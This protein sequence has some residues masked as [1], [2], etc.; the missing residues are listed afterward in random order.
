MSILINSSTIT[1]AALVMLENNLVAGN[2]I[3][4]S[5]SDKF[6]VQDNKIGASLSIRRP[7]FG[8]IQT[9]NMAWTSATAQVTETRVNLAINS[10]YTVALQFTDAD[11]ALR[12]ERFIDRY[13][14]PILS[15]VAAKFDLA[16][17]D[18]ISNCGAAGTS[19]FTGQASDIQKQVGGMWVAGSFSTALSADT[20]VYAKQLLLDA[21]CPDDGDIYGVLTTKGNRQLVTT[22]QNLFNPSEEIAK[23][24]KKGYI[25][26][27]NG[28]EFATS[29]STAAHTN[30]GQATLAIGA[31]SAVLTAGWAETGT[32]TVTSTTSAINAGDVFTVAGV[33]AVN[34][35]TKVQT[36]NLQQFTVVNSYTAGT[37]ALE[38]SPAPITG[39][40]Y[41]NIS[42]TVASKTATLVDA[43]GAT[44]QEGY[45][46]HKSAIVAASPEL[47]LPKSSSF[48]MAEYERSEI[49]E[50][51]VR[52]LQGF[53]MYG[54]GGAVGMNTRIDVVFGLKIVRPELI[55]RI[56][57]N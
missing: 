42:T 51:G 23:V 9:N 37:T 39:G 33:Y 54:V 56:R 3:D 34:P 30:G 57:S 21:G 35:L 24:Y 41:Q 16:I 8:N 15:Q 25:G 27:Y 2:K 10:T 17:G 11:L 48:N 18:A 43:A 1:K 26:G 19:A 5:Y 4:W 32:F 29:Q 6:A 31:G 22:F 52:L 47:T 50:L 40:E 55:V 38:V 28:I 13:I 46:F 45:I 53:D 20:L 12:L 14:K 7:V 36:T 49:T 44:G